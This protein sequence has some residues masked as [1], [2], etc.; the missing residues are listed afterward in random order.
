MTMVTGTAV[1]AVGVRST[2]VSMIAQTVFDTSRAVT[3]CVVNNALQA[4]ARLG[5]PETLE[6]WLPNQDLAP[7]HWFS[8]P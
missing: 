8:V 7:S 2:K 1:N 3:A 6:P 4:A 5:A